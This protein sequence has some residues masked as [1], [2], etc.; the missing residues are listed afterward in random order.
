MAPAQF[1]VDYDGEPASFP[2]ADLSET[3]FGE[4]IRGEGVIDIP[5][6]AGDSRASGLLTEI[7]N[8]EILG[9][10]VITSSHLRIVNDDGAWEGTSNGALRLKNKQGQGNPYNRGASIAILAGEGAYDRFDSVQTRECHSTFGNILLSYGVIGLLLFGLIVWRLQRQCGLSILLYLIPPI[11]YGLSHNGGRQA[12]FW[13]LF[14]LA[15]ATTATARLA[16]QSTERPVQANG[17][18]N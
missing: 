2:E 1:K 7:G 18:A 15:C 10:S 13:M 17:L 6:K 11:C 9:N 14:V 4:S 3:E 5:L 16:V 8:Q 12:E